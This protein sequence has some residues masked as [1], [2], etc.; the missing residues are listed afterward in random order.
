MLLNMQN[1]W[2]H[3]GIF[4]VGP[5]NMHFKSPPPYDFLFGGGGLVLGSYF[6][7]LWFH[8][9][10]RNKTLCKFWPYQLVSILIKFLISKAG[11]CIKFQ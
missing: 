1:L 11:Y 6:E 3:Y 7:K 5:R 2:L 10:Q 8:G 4:V 9:K